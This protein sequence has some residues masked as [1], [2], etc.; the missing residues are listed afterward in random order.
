MIAPSTYK[1]LVFEIECGVGALENDMIRLKKD[2]Q[3]MFDRLDEGGIK[4]EG[5]ILRTPC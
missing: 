1:T 4:Y 5:H 3:T 2:K